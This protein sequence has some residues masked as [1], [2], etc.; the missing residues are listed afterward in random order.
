GA[1]SNLTVVSTEGASSVARTVTD[2]ESEIP[3]V[4]KNLT[5][6][7]LSAL[8][9]GVAGAAI[10][11]GAEPGGRGAN[12]TSPAPRRGVVERAG[13]SAGSRVDDHSG[14]RNAVSCAP[15]RFHD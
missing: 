15:S 1:I 2:V 3:A 4:V 9:D 5:G 7:D 13:A 11:N 10:G 14:R 12:G 6:L 8:L